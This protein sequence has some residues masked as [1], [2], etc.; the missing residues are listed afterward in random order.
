MVVAVL[1]DESEHA[2]FF[3]EL[4]SNERRLRC[5]DAMLEGVLDW[6]NQKER[7]NTPLPVAHLEG[8]VYTGFVVAAD[9]HE[10]YVVAHKLDLPVEAHAL[11]IRLIYGIA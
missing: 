2:V 8:G 6:R 3:V 9:A 1:T 11:F 10:S 5:A 7:R 4:N